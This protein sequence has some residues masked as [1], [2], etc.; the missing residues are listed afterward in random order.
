MLQA[1]WEKGLAPSSA[2]PGLRE[3]LRGQRTRAGHQPTMVMS[4]AHWCSVVHACSQP[5][6]QRLCLCSGH[7]DSHPAPAGP[8]IPAAGM[9]QQ[10]TSGPQGNRDLPRASRRSAALPTLKLKGKLSKTKIRPPLR[11]Y[12]GGDHQQRPS[13]QPGPV[14]WPP[15]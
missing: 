12:R 15:P 8:Q 13:A 9:A 7:P 6:T 10:C 1:E 4:V 14:L 3:V 11:N 2:S 5:P